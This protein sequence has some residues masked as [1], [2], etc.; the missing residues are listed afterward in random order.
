MV[1]NCLPY[2]QILHYFFLT[3]HKVCCQ[4]C[5]KA[6]LR[7]VGLCMK[8]LATGKW[9]VGRMVWWATCDIKF[10]LKRNLSFI[11]MANRHMKRCSTLL[12]IGEMQV[13]NT[14]RHYLIQ[15]RMAII[16]KSTS[17]K[18]WRGCGEKETFL[19]YRWEGKL[20]QL[21]GITVWRLLKNLKI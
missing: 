10:H 14:T 19:H 13:K 21:L 12:F 8:L 7:G 5:G 17:C 4:Q 11:R 2:F 16:K 6:G 1:P 18:C 9:Y 3:D 20:V 15:I